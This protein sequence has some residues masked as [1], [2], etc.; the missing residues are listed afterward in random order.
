VAL[1]LVRIH[2]FWLYFQACGPLWRLPW[3]GG[4]GTSFPVSILE[5]QKWKRRRR[6]RWAVQHLIREDKPCLAAQPQFISEAWLS[7]ILA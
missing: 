3:S 2:C 6:G 4:G 5:A 7:V 1:F